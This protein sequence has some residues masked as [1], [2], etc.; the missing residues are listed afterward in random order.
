MN[1]RAILFQ[2]TN[3]KEKIKH[4]CH[5]AKN[6]FEEF[7]PFLIRTEDEKTS[8]YLDKLLWAHP[9][10]SFMPHLVSTTPC[11]E[12]ICITHED[13]NPNDAATCFNLTTKPILNNCFST[14][15]D[16]EDLSNDEKKARSNEKIQSYKDSSFSIASF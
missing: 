7:K 10:Q 14:I 1:Q 3:S 15:Y 2:V 16:F 4:L 12:I 9:V 8:E 6:Q 13:L 5:I 11:K